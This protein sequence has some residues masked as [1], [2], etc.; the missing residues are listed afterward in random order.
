MPSELSR[1]RPPTGSQEVARRRAGREFSQRS[2]VWGPVV[3]TC[4][5][6]G[7]RRAVLST[8]SMTAADECL[9]GTRNPTT[10]RLF[11]VD[12]RL[13]INNFGP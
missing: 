2:D 1:D 11:E 6:F 13:S 9:A 3:P 12:K 5:L 8:D 7:R 10:I 4:G